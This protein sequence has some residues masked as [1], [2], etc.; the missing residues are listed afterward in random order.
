MRP[1]DQVNVYELNDQLYA[2]SLH[3][4]YSFNLRG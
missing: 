1:S 3:G 2:G 4:R